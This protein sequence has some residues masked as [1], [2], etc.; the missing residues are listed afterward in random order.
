MPLI[1][2]KASGDVTAR[3]HSSGRLGDRRQGDATYLR[4]QWGQRPKGRRPHSIHPLSLATPQTSTTPVLGAQRQKGHPPQPQLPNADSVTPAALALQPWPR[5]HRALHPTLTSIPPRR[6]RPQKAP[7]H[8]PVFVVTN[9]A[10]EPWARRGG[11]TFTFV[12]DGVESALAQARAAAGDKD[13]R[14]S[15]GAGL[16]RQYLAAGSIDEFTI[17][18]APVLLGEGTRLFDDLPGAAN[19]KL[20]TADRVTH[21]EYRV[22]K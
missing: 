12:T 3:E 21:L 5:Q 6:P 11:T 19:L 13:V 9:H 22:A 1:A 2:P 15:G 10:R 16:V 18:L 17:H 20:T 8:H 4:A 14:I 7:F